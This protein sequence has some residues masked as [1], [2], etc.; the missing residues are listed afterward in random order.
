[1]K[2]TKETSHFKIMPLIERF[3]A[4]LSWKLCCS[5]FFFLSFFN[6]VN[7][8]EALLV[9]LDR[10]PFSSINI[11][12]KKNKEKV[13]GGVGAQG[14]LK[15]SIMAYAGHKRRNSDVILH[16]LS[17][18]GFTICMLWQRFGWKQLLSIKKI[19]IICTGNIPQQVGQS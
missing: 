6:Y 17:S 5:P 1:M 2:D 7:S 12:L 10:S 16:S 18:Y 11:S 19:S 8:V 13:K 14:S 9:Q 15:S 4:E 3:E